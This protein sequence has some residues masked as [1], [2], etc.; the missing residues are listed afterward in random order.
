MLI[1]M[2]VS[3]KSE[4]HA[5]YGSHQS[6]QGKLKASQM[7]LVSQEILIEYNSLAGMSQRG[8][9]MFGVEFM[10]MAVV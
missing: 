7:C 5:S 10:S 8:S 2:N 6:W 3:R 1:S 9:K 4:L